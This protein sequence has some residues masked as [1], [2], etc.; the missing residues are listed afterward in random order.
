M[1]YIHK[2]MS[3]ALP[4][5]RFLLCSKIRHN[6]RVWFFLPNFFGIFGIFRGIPELNIF[7]FNSVKKEKYFEKKD[8]F[9]TI[10]FRTLSEKDICPLNSVLNRYCYSR[11]GPGKAPPGPRPET[12]AGAKAPSG[13][14][15]ECWPRRAL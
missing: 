8:L 3:C 9:T 6:L 4:K 10:L 12:L 2:N 1:Q 15:L 14:G 5:L 13:R 11:G 7:T